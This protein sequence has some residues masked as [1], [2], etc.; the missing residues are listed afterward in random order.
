MILIVQCFLGLV[1]MMLPGMLEKRL[2]LE[3]P[4]YIFVMYF[5]FL[6][7][8]IFLG[9]VQNFYI[10]IPSWDLI[11]HTFSGVI[12]G[13]LGFSLVSV[14]NNSASV[15]VDLSPAFLGLFAFCFALAAGVVWEIYEFALDSVLGFNMQKAYTE[16]GEALAGSQALLDTMTDLIVDAAGALVVSVIGVIS[17]KKRKRNE[18]N[19]AQ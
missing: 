5:V 4:T 6:F 3:I 17:I 10:I 8:A 13:A 15:R 11:L 19:K 1:V 12:L 16:A 14:F 2:K 18:N 9:E 7:G